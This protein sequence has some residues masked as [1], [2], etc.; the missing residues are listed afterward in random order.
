[1]RLNS[2]FSS[3]VGLYRDGSRNPLR[4]PLVAFFLLIAGLAAFVPSVYA[5]SPEIVLRPIA[6]R[7]VLAEDELTNIA[8]F[9][10][11]SRST[12]HITTLGYSANLFSLDVTEV[13][14]GTGTGFI[15]DDS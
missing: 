7:G 8:V 4:S 13:P 14:Q 12:V 5:A 15:W 9:K 11:A 1:M 3:N 2:F 6:P 10:T